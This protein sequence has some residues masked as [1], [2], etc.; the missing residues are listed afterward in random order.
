MSEIGK[1]YD[2]RAGVWDLDKTL[3]D[4]RTAQGVGSKLLL[5]ELGSWAL[6]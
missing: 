4:G 2:C 1:I 5:R 3:V 6:G